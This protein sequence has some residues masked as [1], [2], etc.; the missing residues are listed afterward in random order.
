MSKISGKELPSIGIDQSGITDSESF[1]EMYLKATMNGDFLLVDT[2]ITNQKKRF[3]L[4]F[5][6][7]IS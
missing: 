1:K 2:V 7:T 6:D 3:H 4:D 5:Y